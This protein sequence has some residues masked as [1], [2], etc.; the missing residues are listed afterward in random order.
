MLDVAAHRL[1]HLGDG[2]RVRALLDVDASEHGVGE[3]E[4]RIERQ[5]LL[6]L[7]GGRAVV[8]CKVQPL[9]EEKVLD[10]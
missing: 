3:C 7:R 9:P 1:L 4:A 5:G 8:A 6:D 10:R 2:G